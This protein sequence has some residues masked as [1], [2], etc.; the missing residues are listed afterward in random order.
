MTFQ[1][2]SGFGNGSMWIDREI[3]LDEIAKDEGLP[4]LI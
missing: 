1:E 3:S 2:E 4:L